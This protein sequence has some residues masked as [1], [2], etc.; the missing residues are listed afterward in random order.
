MGH[1]EEG[2][3]FQEFFIG[4]ATPGTKLEFSVSDLPGKL[5]LAFLRANLFS[6]K[7]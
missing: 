1:G 7:P 5:K 2:T 3:Q 6:L 4:L